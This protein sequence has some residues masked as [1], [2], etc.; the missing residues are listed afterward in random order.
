MSKQIDIVKKLW[1]FAKILKDDGVTYLQYTTELTYLLFLKM[2][3]ELGKDKILP[4]NY[5]WNDLVNKTGSTQY[6]FYRKMLIELGLSKDF[7]LQIL[8]IN[9][10][11]IVPQT[12]FANCRIV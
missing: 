2:N 8:S 12:C 1:G 6:N 11:P 3:N 9:C 10:Y 5:R 4:K 7:Y